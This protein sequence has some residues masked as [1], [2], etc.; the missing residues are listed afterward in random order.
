MLRKVAAGKAIW[1]KSDPWDKL[2]DWLMRAG[3][4]ASKE[5]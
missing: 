4:Q 3:G 1:E 2:K 5:G